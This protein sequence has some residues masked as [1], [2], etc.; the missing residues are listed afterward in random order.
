M[1][2][3]FAVP[4]SLDLPPLDRCLGVRP[5]H[6]ANCRPFLNCSG[7]PTPL[8]N[9]V[10]T[11]GPIPGTV[12]RRWQLSLRLNMSAISDASSSI[13]RCKAANCSRYIEPSRRSRIV[14]LASAS[15]T[16][17]TIPCLNWTMPNGKMALDVRFS[18]QKHLRSAVGRLLQHADRRHGGSDTVAYSARI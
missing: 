6:A 12:A 4:P 15:A 17:A 3:C 13:H 8:N 10:A 1:S 11:S 18:E 7:S 14:I 5:N 16:E 2:P 9:A